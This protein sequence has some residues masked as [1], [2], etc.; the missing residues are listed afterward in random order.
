[1]GGLFMRCEA[2]QESYAMLEIHV[3]K[4]K[5]PAAFVPYEEQLRRAPRWA[6]QEGSMHFDK[7]NQVF[8]TLDRITAKLDELGVPYAL[9]GGLALFLH[10]YRRFTEDVDL[11]VTREGLAS[12]HEK[13]EGLG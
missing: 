13:L 5:A 11:L 4:S 9:A 7:A 12:I 10:G 2:T 1:M 3:D 6:L 8:R